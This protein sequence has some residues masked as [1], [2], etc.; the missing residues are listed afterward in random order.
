MY[1]QIFMVDV[2]PS[3]KL[4]TMIGGFLAPWIGLFYGPNRLIPIILLVAVTA[5]DWITGIAAAKKDKT[6]SSEYGIRQGVPR[7]MFL[8]ALPVI[9]NLFDQ[10]F[11]LPGLLFYAITLGLIYHTWQSLTA[12]AYRAGWGKWIPQAVVKLIESEL[13]AKMERATKRGAELTE[14]TDPTEPTERKDS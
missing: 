1:K 12:N 9:A 5:M 13:R 7:T 3:T 10:M 11:V 4:V 2:T 6:Y 14:S 8:L